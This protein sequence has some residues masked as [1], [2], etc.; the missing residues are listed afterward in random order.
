MSPS[1]EWN[2]SRDL[3]PTPRFGSFK[4]SHRWF[5]HAFVALAHQSRPVPYS[6]SF[7]WQ[8]H[9]RFHGI[10]S[11]QIPSVLSAAT[12]ARTPASASAR[13]CSSSFVQ[14][15]QQ[16]VRPVPALPIPPSF[17]ADRVLCDGLSPGHRPPIVDETLKLNI[18]DKVDSSPR[19]PSAKRVRPAEEQAP[20]A[21]ATESSP[22]A[23]GRRG[24]CPRRRARGER[25]GGFR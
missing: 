10:N 3:I 19:R 11:R 15:R 8:P 17:P 23:G 16:A 14:W 5:S 12:L 2:V 22:E 25:R 1:A 18:E 24:R 13:A 6:S 9:P 4:Q 7:R 21:V 20:P